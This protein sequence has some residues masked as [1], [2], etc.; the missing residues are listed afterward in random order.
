[1]IKAVIIFLVGVLFGSVAIIVIAC[2][3]VA[4]D[5]DIAA[6]EWEIEHD[7]QQSKR[8]EG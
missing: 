4:S 6:S 1:M 2:C 7:K 3:T 5:A 8:Q